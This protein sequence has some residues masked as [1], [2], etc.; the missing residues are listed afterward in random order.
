MIERIDVQRIVSNTTELEE[1]KRKQ[2]Q[3]RGEN[4][5][6]SVQISG[7]LPSAEAVNYEDLS[8]KVENIRA[9]LQKNAYEVSPEK[10]LLGLEKYLS[11]K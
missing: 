11:S 6:V 8:R 4:P 5:G 7:R 2:F 10:I 1:R 9:Q 3:E